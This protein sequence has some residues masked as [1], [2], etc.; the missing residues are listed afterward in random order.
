MKPIDNILTVSQVSQR[1]KVSEETVRR[2]IRSKSLNAVRSGREF[3]VSEW[4]LDSFILT[5]GKPLYE[6]SDL[7]IH[8]SLGLHPARVG[9]FLFDQAYFNVEKQ[10]ERIQEDKIQFERGSER[11]KLE[12]SE[13]TQKTEEWVQKVKNIKTTTDYSELL[14]QR[15]TTNNLSNYW[16][17]PLRTFFMDIHFY[18]VA[19][20]GLRK[21]VDTLE[22]DI[23]QKDFSLLIDKYRVILKTFKKIRGMMEHLDEQI[24]N[25]K[26]KGDL[27]NFD[28]K[29]F[30]F[31]NK[32][33]QFYIEDI[34]NLRNEICDYFLEKTLPEKDG[35]D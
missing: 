16:S 19:I 1:L 26:I 7:L 17:L 5:G 28:S 13:M 33:Y 30:H 34:R 35:S 11:Q 10:W 12:I 20:E 25:P 32:Y 8:C 18:F 2:W 31:G 27:G 23:N 14:S 9:S 6:N 15:P 4:H 3:F 22:K 21:A 24:N 29:G